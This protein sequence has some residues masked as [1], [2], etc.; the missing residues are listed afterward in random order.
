MKHSPS[1]DQSQDSM[2]N[3]QKSSFWI[4]VLLWFI[5]TSVLFFLA[6][7]ILS[8][9]PRYLYFE[10]QVSSFTGLWNR[11]NFDGIHYLSIARNGYQE[12]QQGFFFLYPLIIKLTAQFTGNYLTAGVGV[13]LISLLLSLVFFRKLFEKE[14]GSGVLNL[15]LCL[16][17]I[18]PASFFLGGVYTESFFLLLTILSFYWAK[19]RHWFLAAIATALATMTRAMGLVLIVA[20]L[21]EWFTQRQEVKK[22]SFLPLAILPLGII[23]YMLFQ[24]SLGNDPLLSLNFSGRLH[25]DQPT[26]IVLPYQVAYRYARMLLTVGINQAIYFTILLEAASALLFT[27]LAVIG[28]L[29]KVRPSY[30]V[31]LALGAVAPS[32]TGTLISEPRFVLLLFPGFI[33][34]SQVIKDRPVLKF[35]YVILSLIGLVVANLL[36][37]AG[38]WVA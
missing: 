14:V 35:F 13:S 34:L 38:Y 21:V 27:L 37:G 2:P 3:P 31:Y 33:I 5:L 24:F 17:L 22:P 9:S 26:E 19:N 28:Y 29:K 23:I 30:L 16:L 8:A 25:T 12:G 10:K 7:K 18:F 6:P 36:F 32:L 20:M 15:A 1:T 11:A 4:I